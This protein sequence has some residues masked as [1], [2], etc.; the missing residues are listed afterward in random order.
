M[1]AGDFVV[2][3][4]AEK[5]G[6]VEYGSVHEPFGASVGLGAG[7][8]ETDLNESGAGDESAEEVEH[9]GKAHNSGKQAD[10][11]ERRVDEPPLRADRKWGNCQRKRMAKSSQ[12]PVSSLPVAAVHPIIGGIAPG[13][14]PMKVA[15]TVRFLSGVYASR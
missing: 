13:I 6:D 12:A 11:D 8:P 14:A 3:H 5:D 2:H 4:E 15:Q 9:T 1:S 10:G 7:R